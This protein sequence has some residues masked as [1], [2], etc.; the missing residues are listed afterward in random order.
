MNSNISN[1]WWKR[2]KE[3]ELLFSEFKKPI[4]GLLISHSSVILS[5]YNFYTG[6][7]IEYEDHLLWIT[8]GHV[9]D[10]IEIILANEKETP[11]MRWFDGYPDINAAS[12]PINFHKIRMNSWISSGLDAGVIDIAPLERE[13]LLINKLIKPMN[14]KTCMRSEGVTPEGYFIVGFPRI[15]NI[16]NE[17]PAQ[18][19]KTL[20]SLQADY[21]C[22]PLEKLEFPNDD[23]NTEFFDKPDSFYGQLIDKQLDPLSFVKDIQFMSGSPIFSIHRAEDERVKCRLVGILKKWLPETRRICAEP[24]DQ[25]IQELNYWFEEENNNE[26]PKET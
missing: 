8:A 21:A 2:P 24:I 11:I 23:P 15:F 7:L 17:K 12:I 20:K 1:D 3:I 25:V 22:I 19:N 9:I 18:G 14:N 16:Y 4:I 6:F 13:A 5:K 26:N 10:E